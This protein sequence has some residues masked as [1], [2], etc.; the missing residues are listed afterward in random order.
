MA[1]FTCSAVVRGG[2]SLPLYDR[3]VSAAAPRAVVLPPNRIHEQTPVDV[4]SL[5]EQDTTWKSSDRYHHAFVLVG[6]HQRYLLSGSWMVLLR[7]LN[8]FLSLLIMCR[9][10]LFVMTSFVSLSP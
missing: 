1:V 6:H 8:Q 10:L 4:A 5:R 7:L 9:M 3:V 2:R